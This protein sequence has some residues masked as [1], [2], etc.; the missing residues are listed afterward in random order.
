MCGTSRDSTATRGVDDRGSV[1]VSAGAWS[2][3]LR[4]TATRSAS[5]PR[6][7]RS[8]ADGS[9]TVTYWFSRCSRGDSVDSMNQPSLL[10]SRPA[11]G[12]CS[13][14]QWCTSTTDR[15]PYANRAR[16]GM[17]FWLS[18]TTSGRTRRSGPS[19]MRAATMAR[20]ARTYTL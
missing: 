17:P 9:D 6:S 18:I 1:N 3:P 20:P 8:R 7:V 12:H 5:T 2:S 4:T 10:I 15:R 16:K 11:T 19:P 13:R 14:W